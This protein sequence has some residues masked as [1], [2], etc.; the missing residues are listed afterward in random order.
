MSF[1]ASATDPDLPANTLT[2][3]LD[4]GAP[5]GATVD[6]V[7]G[8]FNWT[9]TEAQGPGAYPV[10]VRVTDDGTPNLDDFETITI[11]VS[12]LNQPPVL[13]AIGNQVVDEGTRTQLHSN[14]HRR[15][16]AREHVDLQ[17]GRR[18]PC[19]R[20]DRSGQRR[21]QLDTYRIAGSGHLSCH[22]SR[23]RRWHAQF[24]RFRSD[25][26]YG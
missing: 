13:S 24:G 12:E 26:N 6:P 5:A 2:F 10:T 7:S 4:A 25:H 22:D 1:V 9:P 11:T 3:S 17:P 16:P 21:I 19:R 14:G 20:H 15:R 18:R 8:V 23:H